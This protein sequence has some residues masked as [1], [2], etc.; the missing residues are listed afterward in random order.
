MSRKIL[1][2]DPIDKGY[3]NFLRLNYKFNE[4][5][6]ETLLVHATSFRHPIKDKEY[7]I[8]GLLIRDISYYK[9]KLFRNVIEREKPSII[10]IVN[11]SFV[12]DRAIVN[13]AKE[14]N[15]KIVYLA[16]GSLTNPA[17]FDKAREN[18]DTKIKG[19]AKR[20]F[21]MKNLYGLWNYIDSKKQ[22][23]KIPTFFK[24]IKGIMAH[25]AQYLTL[26]KY[27]EELD[28]DLMLV[29]ENKDKKLLVEKMNFSENKIKVV[30]NPEITGFINLPILEKK[31]F[32]GDIGIQRDNYVV[33]LDDGLVAN[34]IWTK[35]EWY[36]HLISIAKVL[37]KKQMQLVVKLHPRVNLDEYS[38][39]F[40]E[41]KNLIIPIVETDFK[42]LLYHSKL[43]ISHYSSTIVYAL[44]FYK[45]IIVPKWAKN[46]MALTNKYPEN[47]VVYC[48]NIIKFEK[49]VDNSEI[50]NLDIENINIF[51]KE[52]GVDTSLNSID[53]IV[54]SI[55]SVLEK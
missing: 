1:F 3:R 29:Y 40:I 32:A 23:E 27:D 20:I 31:K 19:N 52:I 25:P 55:L 51:L 13:I 7:L 18:L 6:Y 42:N 2:I 37:E 48:E 24:L 43:V 8:D 11:L 28:A 12:L 33:Y 15:I 22:K 9:T 5:G 36:S 47:I 26:A 35:D 17:K 30:G 46:S 44:L 16:H 38:E 49:E 45:K 21:S 53:L 10:L 41:N 39:F 14:K 54:N 34:K 50:N 4:R